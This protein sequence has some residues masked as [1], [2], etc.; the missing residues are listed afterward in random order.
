[1][2]LFSRLWIGG[3][4][5]VGCL[6]SVMHTQGGARGYQSARCLSL[7]HKMSMHQATHRLID[8]P[9]TMRGKIKAYEEHAIPTSGE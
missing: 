4:S 9:Y 3:Q 6:C 8:G 5:A 1:M 2:F 7:V